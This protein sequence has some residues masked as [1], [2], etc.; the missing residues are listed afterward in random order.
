M[1][2]VTRETRRLDDVLTDFLLFARP[3]QP[4]IQDMDLAGEL[5]EILDLFMEQ[6]RRGPPVEVVRE[7]APKLTLRADP[8]KMKQ[9]F[10]N[11]LNN[12][13]E[14][15]PEGGKLWIKAGWAR[16]PV[17]SS[18]V[19]QLLL[20]VRDSGV[21]IPEEILGQIFDPFFTTKDG[22]TGLGL[23]IV[24][25]S[26]ES[27]GGRIEVRS[28]EGIGTRFCLLIPSQPVTQSLT[29]A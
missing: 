11:L 3:E 16:T 10:W 4:R 17:E 21:G 22:G 6:D 18:E 29:V 25:R 27:L 7:I 5:R 23:S 28:K 14:A 19:P 15:M 20:E 9:V 26:L 24:Q 12:A 13:L 2:I 8:E 1:Q